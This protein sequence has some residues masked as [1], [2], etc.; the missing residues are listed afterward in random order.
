MDE[1]NLY[2]TNFDEWLRLGLE[3]LEWI[4]RNEEY[5]PGGY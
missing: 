2:E 1:H 4:K 5:H 3:E